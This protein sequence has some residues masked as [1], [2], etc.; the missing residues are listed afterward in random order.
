MNLRYLFSCFYS[1]KSVTK[2]NYYILAIQ[3]WCDD[4][5]MIHGLW[6]Q[7]DK[8]SYPSYC[9]N[10][11]YSKPT[12]KL[13][14]KMN[15]YWLSCGDPE[16]LWEH[17]W[18]KHGSCVNNQTGMNEMEFFNKTIE[19]F[20]EN[21]NKTLLCDNKDDCILGCFDLNFNEFSC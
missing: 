7:Y 8:D 13:L 17:E 14:D 2:Y 15:T 11:S 5:Y 20:E 16:Q 21:N 9:K 6:P 12:G 1:M 10:V 3:K 19:L 18:E 4:S